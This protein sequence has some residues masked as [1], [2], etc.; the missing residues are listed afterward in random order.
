[1]NKETPA[2]HVVQY[3]FNDG[4]KKAEGL[5]TARSRD[6]VIRAAAIA[7]GDSYKGTKNALNRLVKE[8]TGGLGTSC[9][10]GT[11]T[12]VAHKYLTDLGWKLTLTK[13]AYLHDFDFSGRTVICCLS[14]HNMCVIDNVVQDTWDSRKSRRTKC[15]SPK[16]LGFYEQ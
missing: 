16:L 9:N 7:N 12:P 11:P 1:M 14:S 2:K 5:G 13:G 3:Q 15:G 10:N 4:G 6:C 8:M